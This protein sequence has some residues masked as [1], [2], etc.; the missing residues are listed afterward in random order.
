M[1]PFCLTTKENPG[2][3]QLGDRLMKGLWNQSSPQMGILP[4]NEVGRIVQYVR[5]GEGRKE[6]NDGVGLNGAIPAD[7]GV[8]NCGKKA[9]R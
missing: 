7:H 9:L 3:P 8:M 4:P 2:K 5:E 6:G 1:I